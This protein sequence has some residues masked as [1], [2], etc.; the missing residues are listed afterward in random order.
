MRIFAFIKLIRDY[1]II[2]KSKLFDEE[3]YLKTYADVRKK[4]H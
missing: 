4:R 2:K 3:Y 1:W